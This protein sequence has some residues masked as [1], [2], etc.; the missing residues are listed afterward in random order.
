M[1]EQTPAWRDRHGDIWTEGDDGLMHTRETAPFT[2][3]HVV[4]KWGPL[5]P[6]SD[7]ARRADARR[8]ALPIIANASNY[9]LAVVPHILGRDMSGVIAAVAD[10]FIDAGYRAPVIVDDDTRLALIDALS[11]VDETTDPATIAVRTIA[12]LQGDPDWENR[13]A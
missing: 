2:R 7:A 6:T 12:A 8:V 13:E 10:A 1:T 9:P 4:K 11:Y 5:V 3:E